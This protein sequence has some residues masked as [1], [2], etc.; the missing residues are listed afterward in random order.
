MSGSADPQLQRDESNV[1][2]GREMQVLIKLSTGASY[3]EIAGELVITLDT[4]KTH[5]RHIF[6]KLKARNGAHA[7]SRG[8]Q[9]RLLSAG[10]EAA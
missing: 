10:K 6:T 7:V 9:L 2:S 5:V 3:K 1:L 4:V 8:Y